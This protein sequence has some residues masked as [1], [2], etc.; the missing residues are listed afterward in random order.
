M[1]EES[2]INTEPTS[3]KELLQQGR[4][5]MQIA[6]Q[7]ASI[8]KR[9]DDAREAGERKEAWMPIITAAR[10]ALP[11]YLHGFLREPDCDTKPAAYDAELF[12]EAPKCVSIKIR[13]ELRGYP[14]AWGPTD[15]AYLVPGIAPFVNED[16]EME[17]G[18]LWGTKRDGSG[19][20]QADDIAAAFALAES[21]WSNM[22]RAQD[23]ADEYN[24][25][26]ARNARELARPK[27]AA[28]KPLTKAE[29]LFN[30]IQSIAD[31]CAHNAI[32]DSPI[33]DRII[34]RS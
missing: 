15:Y 2:Y 19:A 5:R 26:D 6:E 16:D 3:L 11:E 17:I 9:E 1:I 10:F 8:K 34:S 23:V 14:A 29:L 4:N 33:I 7:L 13:L 32:S 27:A 21:A 24:S 18:L 12:I 30:L 22:V 20:L 25:E 31:D 28:P